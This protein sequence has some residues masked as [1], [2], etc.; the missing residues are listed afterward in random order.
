MGALSLVVSVHAYAVGQEEDVRD[1][2][3]EFSLNF[4]QLISTLHPPLIRN[5]RLK[6]NSEADG[7]SLLV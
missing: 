4:R 1:L 2:L 6:P 3:A 5:V 7:I